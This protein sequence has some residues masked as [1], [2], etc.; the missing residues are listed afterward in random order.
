VFGRRQAK[1]RSDL[2]R[3]EFAASLDLFRQAAAHAA[4]GVGATVGPQLGM[5][6]NKASSAR[7]YI[8]PTAGRVTN[9][10]S[11]GW[12]STIAAFAPLAE[13]AR[14]GAT[15]AAKLPPKNGG[16]GNG[17]KMNGGKDKPGTS[18][19][20]ITATSEESHGH[21]TLYAL[22]ATGVAVGAAGALVARR[23]TRAK[24]SEYEPSSVT[25]DASS[26]RDAGAT[27]TK[28]SM[29]HDVTD[30]DEMPGGMHKAVD[31]TKE[32]TKSAMD[33]LRTKIHDATGGHEDG[34]MP[35]ATE[36]VNEGASHLAEKADARYNDAT[37]RAGNTM[38]KSGEH[39]VSR[40]SNR[41]EDEVDELIR[42]A[43]NGRM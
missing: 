5:A 10:A 20:K 43:K 37:S 6:K 41:V 34:T 17:G 22:L 30:G 38:P 21:G 15:R 8:A 25:S 39:G 31:W 14:Q 2:V 16:K 11:S 24:W 3:A 26:F 4:G 35:R 23:R 40:T 28:K 33:S 7:G 29:A 12:D 32:H 9:A 18:R 27:S 13:S 42:S 19:L 36:K 1:T